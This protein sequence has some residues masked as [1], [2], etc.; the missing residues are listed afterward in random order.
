MGGRIGGGRGKGGEG[1]GD[2]EVGEGEKEEEE[3]IE[4]VGGREGGEIVGK[5]VEVGE[6]VN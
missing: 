1:F 6:E 5:R 2:I 3:E 4:G